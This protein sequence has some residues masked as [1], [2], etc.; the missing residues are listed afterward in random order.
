MAAEGGHFPIPE[1]TTSIQFDSWEDG[2]CSQCTAPAADNS[3]SNVDD[4]HAPWG[5]LA[6][7]VIADNPMDGDDEDDDAP[8]PTSHACGR[9]TASS[10]SSQDRLLPTARLETCLEP[11]G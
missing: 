3:G 10:S 9:P 7:N 2:E 1:G 4:E 11:C 6:G 8:P 5:E